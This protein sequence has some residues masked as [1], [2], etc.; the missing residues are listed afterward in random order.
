[1]IAA[2]T[3]ALAVVPTFLLLGYFRARDLNPEPARML[4]KTF[5][6]GVLICLP[7]I[8]VE[9]LAGKL[10]AP[11]TALPYEHGLLH[12]MFGAAV[13]EEFFKLL[14]VVFVCMRSREFDEPMDGIVYGAVASLGFASLE[15]LLYIAGDD[16]SMRVASLRA[17]TAVPGHAFMGAI[18]GYYAGQARFGPADERIASWAKAYGVP[19][20]LHTLYDFP[21]LTIQTLEKLQHGTATT[22]ALPFLT[23]AVLIFEWRMT[24]RLV[25]LLRGAQIGEFK[26]VVAGIATELQATDILDAMA[27]PDPRPTAGLGWAMAIGGGAAAMAGGVFSLLFAAGI[28]LS[29]L[30]ADQISNAMFGAA[31]LGLAPLVAGFAVFIKGAKRI[32]ASRPEPPPVVVARSAL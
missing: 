6:W 24:V 13:P 19:V 10:L 21:A 31:M 28:A 15:N 20:V 5:G 27:Q 8:P 23:I 16:H 26:Q 4:W 17:F 7:V 14:V 18:M 9:M 25:H 2:L 1:M 32:H 29:P 30:Q 22:G 11:L 12:A 3:V